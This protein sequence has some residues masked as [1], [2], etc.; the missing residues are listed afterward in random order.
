[1]R[2]NRGVVH[3]SWMAGLERMFNK[4]VIAAVTIAMLAVAGGSLSA[5]ASEDKK[6]PP[7]PS[8]SPSVDPTPSPSEEPSPSSSQTPS[9][10]PTRT[11]TPI[12]PPS[13]ATGPG[14]GASPTASAPPTSDQVIV[15]S[16]LSAVEDREKA[17]DLRPTA[18]GAPEQGSAVTP[19]PDPVATSAAPSPT[20]ALGGL[21]QPPTEP[22][23]ATFQ[24]ALL[25]SAILLPVLIWKAYNEETKQ[26]STSVERRLVDWVSVSVAGVIAGLLVAKLGEEGSLSH[27]AFTAMGALAFA[28]LGAVMLRGFTLV[29]VR[30]RPTAGLRTVIRSTSLERDLVGWVMVSIVGIVAGLLVVEI[31]LD[32]EWLHQGVVVLS[33]LA[34]AAVGV[35]MLRGFTPVEIYCVVLIWVATFS[36]FLTDIN[37]GPISAN[38][39]WTLVAIATGAVLWVTSPRQGGLSALWALLF[40]ALQGALYLIVFPRSIPGIQSVLAVFAFILCIAIVASSGQQLRSLVGRI[41]TTFGHVSWIAIGLYGATVVVLGPGNK[42]VLGPR[43]FALIALIPLAWSLARWRYGERRAGIRALGLLGVILLSLS[44][45]ATAIGLLLWPLSRLSSRV[46]LKTWVRVVALVVT[47]LVVFYA[48]FELI[49]PLRDRFLEGD[50]RSVGGVQINVSGRDDYWPVVWRSALTSPWIGQGA[51]SAETALLGRGF[52]ITHPHNEYLRIFHDFGLLGLL[53]WLWGFFV[54]LGRTFRAWRR[55]DLAGDGLAYVHLA[56]WL[57][58]VSLALGMVTDNSLRYVHVLLPLGISVGCSLGLMDN[59]SR[60]GQRE[61]R[62]TARAR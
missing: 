54:L 29:L 59:S 53:F 31:G 55:A 33:S 50:V 6:P 58:L 52:P 2:D 44:R 15:R 41:S 22:G 17:T 26:I 39:A 43:A 13:P 62:L 27:Q 4:H 49:T 28:A 38:G 46:G 36:G 9:P 40:F 7:S 47:S 32:G 12:P 19:T 23:S 16:T 5:V 60:Y 18:E 25:I 37:V 8:P 42:E 11:V 10:S 45:L 21:F 3:S 56:A 51:G 35:A 34:F 61:D 14:L 20:P 24:V 57:G 30:L 48:A 1:M